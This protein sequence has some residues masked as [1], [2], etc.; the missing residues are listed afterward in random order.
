MPAANYRYLKKY[1]KHGRDTIANISQVT[2][3]I[4]M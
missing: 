1:E 4:T 3:K 2:N